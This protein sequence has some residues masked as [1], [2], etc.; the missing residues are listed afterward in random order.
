MLINEEGCSRTRSAD[1]RAAA[2]AIGGEK[3]TELCVDDIRDVGAVSAISYHLV[4]RLN[5]E[6]YG[7]YTF[8]END[9]NDYLEV[10]LNPSKRAG[11]A[12]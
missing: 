2:D 9:D 10:A 12:I 3:L 4:L 5:G 11:N 7:L 1:G 8:V 6:F